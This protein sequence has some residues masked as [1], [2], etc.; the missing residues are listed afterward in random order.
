[1]LHNREENVILKKNNLKKN[2]FINMFP[3]GTFQLLLLFLTL[4]TNLLRLLLNILFTI[5]FLFF[6]PNIYNCACD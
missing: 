2:M 4:L 1:M 5:I 3:S 6:L